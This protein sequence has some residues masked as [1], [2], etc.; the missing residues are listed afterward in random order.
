MQVTNPRTK[1]VLG[2]S[3][4]MV[5]ADKVNIANMQVTLVSGMTLA[6]HDVIGQG[7]N[8][9]MASITALSDLFVEHQVK[10]KF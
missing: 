8:V 6:V 4:L 9:K 2:E 1:E 5:A 10:L 3:P 7:S